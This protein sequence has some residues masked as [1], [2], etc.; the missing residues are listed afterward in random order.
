[1]HVCLAGRQ[2]QWPDVMVSGMHL[3]EPAACAMQFIC[4]CDALACA[5]RPSLGQT[6]ERQ[7]VQAYSKPQVVVECRVGD[8]VMWS[9]DLAS[10]DDDL[11]TR[12]LRGQQAELPFSLS[13]PDKGTVSCMQLLCKH[14]LG[15]S[16][17]L[18]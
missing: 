16:T 7:T 17:M 14:P 1:M 4:M 15:Y 5:G 6:D 2:Q 9:Q 8:K 3:P 10:V 11:E 18:G 12:Y 13:V